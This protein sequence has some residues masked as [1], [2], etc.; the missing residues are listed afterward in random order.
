MSEGEL[1]A[2]IRLALSRGDVRLLRNN[3]GVLRDVR[4]NYITY[5]LGVGTSDLVGWVSRVVTLSDIGKRLAIFTA[6]EV[7]APHGR[8]TEEQAAFIRTVREAGGIAGVA[9]SVDEALTLLT[10]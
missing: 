8:L 2:E 1:V 4:G 5:G 3:V 10:I 9:H 6:C 7:K